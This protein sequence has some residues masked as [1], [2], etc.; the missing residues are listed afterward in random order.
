MD[1]VLQHQP[2]LLLLDLHLPD[3][4]GK[5]IVE[6]LRSDKRIGSL[7]IAILSSEAQPKTKEKLF[8][9]GAN[10]YMNKPLYVRMLAAIIKSHT[11]KIHPEGVQKKLKYTLLVRIPLIFV[12]RPQVPD[13]VQNRQ[14]A[15]QDN[16]QNPQ[17]D[18]PVFRVPDQ[19]FRNQYNTSDQN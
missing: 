7:P 16:H 14:G 12:P 18:L 10:Y 6:K 9:S 19:R 11:A 1:L 15:Y 13:Q 8:E 3:M 2:D 5:T 4:H 17:P